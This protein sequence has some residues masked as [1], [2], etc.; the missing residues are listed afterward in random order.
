MTQISA[1]H[2]LISSK[3]EMEEGWLLMPWSYYRSFESCAIVSGELTLWKS[4]RR[5]KSRWTDQGHDQSVCRAK[6]E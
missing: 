6:D 5:W 3:N 1:I 2:F 4:E